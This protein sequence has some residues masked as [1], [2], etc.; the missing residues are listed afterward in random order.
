MTCGKARGVEVKAG[1]PLAT[2][3][4]R[5]EF[6]LS[7]SDTRGLTARRPITRKDIAVSCLRAR[8]E[9]CNKTDSYSEYEL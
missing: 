9:W 6:S 5:D 1:A 8:V 3:T 7:L 2:A 4:H